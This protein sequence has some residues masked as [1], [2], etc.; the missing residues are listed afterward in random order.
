MML[1][2]LLTLIPCMVV[3]T[4]CIY[5]SKKEPAVKKAKLFKNGGSQAVRLPNEFRFEGEFVY[6][7][8]AGRAVILMAHENPWQ[9]FE[10][11]IEQFSEDFM[12]ERNQP[13]YQ[14][15][16]TPFK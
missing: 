1:H 7:K 14:E 3:Y 10:S 2:A 5:I 12:A 13:A 15:R 6:V 9:D 16:D 11:T 4:Q 8:Q